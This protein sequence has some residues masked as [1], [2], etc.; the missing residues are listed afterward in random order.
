VK[1]QHHEPYAGRLVNPVGV[2]EVCHPKLA[3]MRP[4]WTDGAQHAAIRLVEVILKPEQWRYS[5]YRKASQ[6]KLRRFEVLLP[7]RAGSIDEA[8]IRQVVDATPY[9]SYL[10]QRLGALALV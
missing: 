10:R 6:D 5:N 7:V 1:L 8:A 3:R 2:A 4:P 9:W